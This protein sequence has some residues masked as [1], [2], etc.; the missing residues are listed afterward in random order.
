MRPGAGRV[1]CPERSASERLV[2]YLVVSMID[3][4]ASIAE[5][6]NHLFRRLWSRL[7]V[8]LAW[9]V[10]LARRVKAFDSRAEA[11]KLAKRLRDEEIPSAVHLRVGFPSVLRRLGW[12]VWVPKRD[13]T[14][15]RAF[16]I[17]RDVD[18]W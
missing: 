1:R 12:S 10:G 5:L 18:W 6:L 3:D 16:V 4:P 9:I 8:E 13:L 2:L 17:G 15:A 7:A 11:R 14:Q